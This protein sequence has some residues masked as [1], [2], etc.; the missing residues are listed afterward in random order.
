MEVFADPLALSLLD[1][2]PGQGDERWVR[3]NSREQNT[4]GRA[5]LY[6]DNSGPRG[7]PDHSARLPTRREI[8]QYEEGGPDEG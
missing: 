4:A 7:H 8:R 3:A 6:G 2:E 1:E 5:Y